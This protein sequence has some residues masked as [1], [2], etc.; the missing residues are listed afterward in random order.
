[1]SVSY[2]RE[3]ALDDLW[4]ALVRP[5][6]DAGIYAENRSHAALRVLAL[7]KHRLSAD[8]CA[9]SERLWLAARA[10]AVWSLLANEVIDW[11]PSL[12]GETMIPAMTPASEINRM[13]LLT[14]VMV[15]ADADIPPTHRFAIDP[16]VL[17]LDRAV[18]D[19]LRKALAAL[20]QGEVRDILKPAKNGRHEDAWTWDQ[21]RMRGV[22][23]VLYLCGKGST[24]RIAQRRVAGFM[25]ITIEALRKWERDFR[26][27]PDAHFEAAFDAGA[28]SIQLQ[29]D[30]WS[31]DKPV[32]ASVLSMMQDLETEDPKSFGTNYR[33]RYGARH[34]PP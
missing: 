7:L 31:A 33:G 2:T 11:L 15:V 10:N 18:F 26:T 25:G 22:Q 8:G 29:D 3:K 24:K 30:S 27:N 4:D 21:M 9:N 20:I 32:D 28:L 12:V 6:A 1:V 17:T 5:I 19:D 16:V 14:S 34:N 13:Y 23:H